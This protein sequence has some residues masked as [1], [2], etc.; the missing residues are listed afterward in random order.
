MI[1]WRLPHP[2]VPGLQARRLRRLC[3]FFCNQSAVRFS[4]PLTPLFQISGA[5]L[6]TSSIPCIGEN[7]RPKSLG[8]GA[9]SHD[10]GGELEYRQALGAVA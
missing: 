3:T 10:Q 5:G 9:W 8:E 2:P 4:R 6:A 7:K 1:S